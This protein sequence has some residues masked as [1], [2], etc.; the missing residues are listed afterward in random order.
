MPGRVKRMSGAVQKNWGDLWLQI[1]TEGEQFSS[2]K[3]RI[4][5]ERRIKNGSLQVSVP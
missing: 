1:A 4:R 5:L 3:K 2:A